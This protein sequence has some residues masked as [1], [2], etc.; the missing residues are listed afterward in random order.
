MSLVQIIWIRCFVDLA[1]SKSFSR[2]ASKL[3]ISQPSLSKYVKYIES[4]LGVTL[5]DRTTRQVAL[6]QAGECFLE[7]SVKMLSLFDE[8]QSK[9]RTHSGALNNIVRIA[10]GPVVHAYGFDAMFVQFQKKNPEVNMQITEGD[11]EDAMNSLGSGD[12]DFA[13]VRTNL[14]SD[15]GSYRTIEFCKDELVLLCNRE[16]R[17]AGRK[18]ISVEEALGE[19][20]VINKFA[21]PEQRRLLKLHGIAPELLKPAVICT[22]MSAIE[23]YILNGAG[24]SMVSRALANAES[25]RGQL[26]Y[27][28]MKEKLTITLGLVYRDSNL[29]HAGKL[30]VGFARQYLER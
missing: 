6:T 23:E 24:I 9:I 16:H 5:F 18:E 1:Q 14:L 29:S 21:L 15:S 8:M 27:I 7:Y 11:M 10:C 13:V 2:S 30:F 22:E 19:R 20:I 12:A 25:R 26:V 17:F 4:E 28:P 3:F